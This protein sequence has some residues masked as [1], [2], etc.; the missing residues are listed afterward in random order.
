M[1]KQRLLL[2]MLGLAPTV[3]RG[4]EEANFIYDEDVKDLTPTELQEG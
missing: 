1:G 2:S 3:V 4:L